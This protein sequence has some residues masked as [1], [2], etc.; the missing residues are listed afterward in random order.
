MTSD[1][2]P[3]TRRVTVKAYSKRRHLGFVDN[4]I[5]VKRAINQRE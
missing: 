1:S 3:S 2:P 5:I 4:Q